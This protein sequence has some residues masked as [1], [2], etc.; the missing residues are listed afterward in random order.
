MR[1][2]YRN[3]QTFYY[4]L[5]SATEPIYDEWG[6]EV[7]VGVGYTKPVKARGNISPAKGETEARQFGDDVLYDRVITMGDR[8]TPIDENAVL[9]IDRTPQ[10]DAEGNLATDAYGQTVTP[11]NYIVKRVA[12]SLP[13]FGSAQIA[14]KMVNV[15]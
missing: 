13:T 3:E 11:H 10:L 15:S 12:R 5:Y 7:G 14:V 6:N 4:A 1:Q 9:W 8:D 2:S